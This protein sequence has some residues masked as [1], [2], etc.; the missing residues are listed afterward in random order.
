MLTYA[1]IAAGSGAGGRALAE[2]LLQTLSPDRADLANYY[3][4]GMRPDLAGTLG[5]D[6]F[7]TVATELVRHGTT[8]ADFPAA[9]D[10]AMQERHAALVARLVGG[11]SI[12]LD[13]AVLARLAEHVV[14][15][16]DPAAAS[17]RVLARLHDGTVD[18]TDARDAIAAA[19]HRREKVL[20]GV[21]RGLYGQSAAE[22]R[23]DMHPRLAELLGLDSRRVPSAEEIGHVLS[24]RR[25]DGE[26]IGGKSRQK[27]TV[28]LA[29]ALGLDP[30][31][32]PTGDEI[33][34]VLNGRRADGTPI[35]GPGTE[36][37]RS[38]LLALLGVNAAEPTPEQA[39]HLTA[40]RMADGSELDAVAYRRGVEASKARIAAVDLTFSA[41]KSVSVAW[42]LA[43]TEA[44]RNMLAQAHKDAVA[45]TMDVIAG[46]LGHARRGKAGSGGTDAGHIT[47]LGFDHYSSRPVVAV[48]RTDAEGAPYSQL[49]GVGTA[50]DPALHSH[51]LVPSVVMTDTGRV[52]ALDLD[53]MAGKTHS[54]GAIYQAFLATNLKRLG[55]DVAL[56]ER[57]GAA[58]LAAVPDRVREAFS[59]RTKDGTEAAREFAASQG[60]DWDSLSDKQKV[61]LVHASTRARRQSKDAV[62]GNEEDRIA[63]FVAWERQATAM[64]Y[65]HRSV[66]G[67][68]PLP[69]PSRD[70]RLEG[71]YQTALR[72]L[73]KTF[74]GIAKVDAEK[75]R[76]IAA[77]GL[78]TTSIEDVADVKAITR[79]FATRGVR[80]D[81][82]DVA[83]I[84][85][86]DPAVRGKARI[87]VTT[88]L[89]EAQEAEVVEQLRKAAGDRST[90]LSA[91]AVDAAVKR[92]GLSFEGEHGRAQRA[93][94]DA[95]GMGGGFAAFI[96]AAGAG[97]SSV[98]RPLVD[99]WRQDGKRVFGTALGNNQTD[100]L[101][102]AGIKAADRA[103]LDP[104]LRRAAAGKLP[105]DR[106]SVVVIEE[107][108]RVGTRQLREL[109]TLQEERGFKVV[110]VGDPE[111]LQ[112]IEAGHVVGLMRRALG[113][114]AIPEIV[115]TRRQRTEEEKVTTGLFREGRAGE[116]I[117]RKRTDGTAILVAG[118][119]KA[120][121]DRV[122]AL[123]RERVESGADVTVSAPTNADARAVALAIREQR[124]AMG[125]VGAD[126]ISVEATSRSRYNPG[127]GESYEMRLAEGDR[128]RLYER[129]TATFTATDGSGQT[130]HGNIGNNGSVLEVRGISAEG[131]RLRNV[132]GR[133]GLV[134]WETLRDSESGRIRLGWGDALTIDAAQGST[135]GRHILAMPSGSAG[136]NGYQGYTAGSRH[137]D[138]TL[139]VAGDAA[140]RREI[141][142]KRP[143]GDFRPI[144]DGDVWDNVARNLSR[145]PERSSALAFLDRAANVRRGTVRTFQGALER[146]ERQQADGRAPT[147]DAKNRGRGNA[148]TKAVQQ[149]QVATQ[150][151]AARPMTSA[152]ARLAEAAR[153]I[154]PALD[155]AREGARKL[156]ELAGWAKQASL[157]AA[158]GRRHGRGR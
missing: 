101:E 51:M 43:P 92:S 46:E 1:T 15:S 26:E 35:D 37:A 151:V 154:G 102:D 100:S 21:E 62:G 69:T 118:D 16:A 23:R 119:H 5:E 155:R 47:W 75:L 3:Q 64:G 8:L 28:S 61:G 60:K 67:A 89:H 22:P 42:A 32:A 134:R 7:A 132:S 29:D 17:E 9:L 115:T 41:D 24:G 138:E 39:R 103:A 133:E 91:R 107:V 36:T 4:R 125:Q 52:G 70:E 58:R 147:A 109:L 6:G 81:G 82:R 128:V 59:K 65:A 117:E 63:D 68:G 57:T 123:W 33:S 80:Q 130:T 13:T 18:S 55:V 86:E 25:A 96:G 126:L 153:R 19:R 79:A 158:G 83:L 90:A 38:R 93:A 152:R 40:G 30:A 31:R 127:V 20:E 84:W 150:G 116:A 98:L 34:H 77:R 129:A 148:A 87:G 10:A 50:G 48:A 122:A 74:T 145:K 149:R 14:T 114:D 76:E 143:R 53:T 54:W 120:V 97:K 106:D 85:G 140:E 56:D 136:V 94:I 78:V 12:A 135:V 49:M 108:G 131:L 157:G 121:V 71:A 144:N 156:R 73:D 137:R 2:Y 66:L 141:A 44:E 72:L 104:F 27:G 113:D 110:A 146:M 142:A 45:S 11:E 139:I 111:Q 105:L 124:R 99:A 88:T 112:S 95:L